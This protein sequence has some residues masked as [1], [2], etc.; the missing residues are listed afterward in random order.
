MN[1]ITFSLDG[2]NNYASTSSDIARM[3]FQSLNI[4][5]GF[6]CSR[7]AFISEF[8]DIYKFETRQELE[9]MIN[10]YCQENDLSIFDYGTI[11]ILFL[12]MGDPQLKK[13]RF[14]ANKTQGIPERELELSVDDGERDEGSAFKRLFP[15]QLIQTKEPIMCSL[16]SVFDSNG[17]QIMA[18]NILI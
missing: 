2:F 13:I 18:A 16:P 11:N 6:I 12:R 3:L 15:T 17:R 9:T 8:R 10:K 5:K 14:T 1:E 4:D 7:M